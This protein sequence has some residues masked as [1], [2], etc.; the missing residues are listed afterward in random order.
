MD[1]GTSK[2]LTFFA[3]QTIREA[4]LP[5]PGVCVATTV[6]G[7]QL[8]PPVRLGGLRTVVRK[9]AAAPEQGR[10]RAEQVSK[11]VQKL[12]IY[13]RRMRTGVNDNCFLIKR[14]WP[15]FPTKST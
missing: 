13:R 5:C 2:L 11:R 6:A 12:G 7:K 15:R 9:A 4:E 10:H 8:L 3:E 14:T 1:A